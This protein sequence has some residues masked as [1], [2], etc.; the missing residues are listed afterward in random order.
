[1]RTPF[2]HIAGHLLWSTSGRVWAV[3]RVA[4]LPG[5]YLPARVHQDLLGRITSLVRSMPGIEPRLFVL[6]ARTDPGE[7][8]ERMVADVDWQRLPAWAE[9]CAAT[10]DLLTGQEMHERTLWLAVPLAVKG[11]SASASL[12]AL[13]A[14]LSA[15]LDLPPV[16]V[17][18]AE[19]KAA[20]SETERIQ[21]SLGGGLGLRP[22]SAAEIVWML[23]H[24]LCRGLA[25]EPLL[26]DAEQSRLYGSSV[27]EGR[28]QSPSYADL[29]MVR[30]AEGGQET[31]AD[32]KDAK[33]RSPWWRAAASSPLGRRWLQVESEAG[34]GYQAHLVLAE[35]PPAVSVRSAD[36]LAQLEALPFPVDVTVDLRVVTAKKA[37]AQVQRKKRELL[38]QADQYGAQPTGMPHSLPDAAGDLAEQDARMA[39][40]SVEVEIQSV[41]VLS[42]WGPDAGTCDARARELSAALSGGDYRV[43]RPYGMQ[44]E[45]FALGLPGTVRA[46]K[47]GQ[48]TQHQLS[49]DWAACGA[50]T[51]S[52]V[53]DPAGMM[54][55]YDLDCGTI[56]PVLL[57]PADAPQVNASA[58]SAVIGDLGAGKSVLEKLVTE[59]VVDRGGRA[60]VIDRTPMREW[61][62]F[63]RT[64]MGD[65]CQI[66]DAAK[67]R[68]SI[69]PLRVFG[70]PVGAHYALS[71]LTLQLGV[72]AM[73]AAGAVLHHAVEEVS[74]GP[75]PS[76]GKVLDVLAALAASGAGS[77]RGDAAATMADL[78]RIVRTNPLAAMVFD[79]SLPPVTLDGDLGADMVVVTTTGLTLPPREAFADVEVLRQQPLEALIGRAVLYLIAAV[80][81]QAAFTDP[82][83]FCLVSLDEVYWLTSS[84]EGSALVHEI[85][86][87]G[88]KH[89]AGVFL[90]AHDKDELG[91]DA[92]LIAYRF[93]ARTADRAR[94]V[95]GLQFLGLD[96]EDED[97]I[98]MVTTGLSPVGQ[99]GR[100]GEMLL[101]DPRM[102]VGRI[103]VVVP[104]VPRI[105]KSIFTT[106]GRAAQPAAT[107]GT[108]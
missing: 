21:T 37:R 55:G 32:G 87:D 4:A 86:H 26:S 18:E 96:G 75:E 67:A 15:A 29:G 45:L 107:G 80:A 27:R 52:R 34:T 24:A 69:D 43:E 94:A 62:G 23:Q 54:V 9:T 41:T 5:G 77:T 90:G 22:A 98:R 31:R 38:D 65:R 19:V 88:R 49:E 85:L 11:G 61:A 47:L 12:T 95:K 33:A 91:K 51:L 7:I 44:E 82:S 59:A 13:Y 39:R 46:P 66:I 78:L 40:T 8:A 97:L 6:A 72:G 89:G 63:A 70:G 30:L 101:R 92:G 42:V 1:M 108:S 71:Y 58:S 76:M 102:Q 100:E 35:I 14:E 48:F 83:R 81:R 106:P 10:V 20:A 17:A 3:W 36:V 2:R 84:A 56:R 74:G 104:P 53:G 99:A 79:P 57:N 16:P 28:L 60:I 73:T 50:L 93:L 25:E 64:A 103:K 68:I 105:K